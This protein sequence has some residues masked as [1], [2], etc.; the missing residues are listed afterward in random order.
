[1]VA[2]P[3]INNN[4]L[5]VRRLDQH[6]SGDIDHQ[7]DALMIAMLR[8]IC[9]HDLYR[10]LITEGLSQCYASPASRSFHSQSSATQT[11]SFLLRLDQATIRIVAL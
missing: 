2:T 4:D 9:R 5:R 10:S 7:N 1:M 3:P 11:V 6:A 8:L